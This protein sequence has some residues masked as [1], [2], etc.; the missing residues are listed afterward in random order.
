MNAT[1][2]ILREVQRNSGLQIRQFLAEGVREPRQPAKLHPHG[3]VLPLD[4]A[5][6][7]IAHTRVA[8]S[9]LVYNLRDSWWRAP[10]FVVLP[11]IAK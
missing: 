9:H 2:I 8:D 10:P 6:R 11:I 4:V 3:K 5:S 7:N 1:E